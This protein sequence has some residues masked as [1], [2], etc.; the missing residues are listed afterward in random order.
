MTGLVSLV[1]SVSQPG[2]AIIH[3]HDLGA[4]EFFVRALIAT[5]D[6]WAVAH[7]RLGSHRLDREWSE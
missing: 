1:V 5:E 6:G 2:F 7:L 4:D 3:R